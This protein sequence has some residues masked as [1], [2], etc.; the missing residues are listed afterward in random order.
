MSRGTTG[1]NMCG[2]NVTSSRQVAIGALAVCMLSM[3]PMVARAA[4]PGLVLW[5]KLGS[6]S[7]VQNS[8]Y[9]PNLGFFN[10]TGEP[11]IVGNP[12][13]RAGRLRRTASPSDQAV[14]TAATASIRSFGPAWIST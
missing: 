2:P 11:D 4:A 6:Q 3:M 12:A 5:N 13:L 14:T 1:R 9:G 7:E 8:A 10:A